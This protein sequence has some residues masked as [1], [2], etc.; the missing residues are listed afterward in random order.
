MREL[1]TDNNHL[2]VITFINTKLVKLYFS[3]KIYIFNH[4]DINFIF[5]FSCGI[6]CFILNIYLDD[7]QTILKYLKNT[8]VNLNNVLIITVNFNIRDS[9]WNLLY[10]HYS[11]Y[12]NV[13]Q[14]AADSLNLNLSIPINLVL[15]WYADNFQD[16][17][18]VLNLMFLQVDMEKFNNYH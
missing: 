10:P 13:F 11:T 8:E 6:M 15:A 17:N 5:S 14:E 7:Q 18:L 16:S 1:I 9:N 4:W 12:A 2:R 3:L